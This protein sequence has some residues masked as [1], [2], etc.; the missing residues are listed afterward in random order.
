MKASKSI[1]AGVWCLAGGAA[2]CLADPRVRA[3][4]GV[5]GVTAVSA[6]VSKD[7]VRTKLPDGSFQPEAYAFGEGGKWP[8]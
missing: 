3:M 6:K 1:R 2:L 8:G 4:E 5:E 7:Y